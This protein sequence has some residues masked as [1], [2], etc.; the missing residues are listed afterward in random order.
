MGGSERACIR[1]ANALVPYYDVTVATIWGNAGLEEE[2]DNHIQ[3]IHKF[4]NYIRGVANISGRIPAK[5]IYRFFIREK[6]DIEVAVGDGLESY[7][8]SGSKNPNKYSWIHMNLGTYGTKTSD[9]AIKKYLQYKNIICVSQKNKECFIKE[10]GFEDKI[11]VC[12]TPVDTHKIQ[13][14]SEIDVHLP[15]DSIVAVGRLEEVKG[16]DRLIRAV[17]KL[18]EFK[19]KVFIYGDGTQKQALEKQISELELEDKIVLR[20]M[21][22]NPYPYIA[23][24]KAL[25]CSSREESFGFS[26]VEAMLLRTPVLA[27][28]CGGAEEIITRPE[29]GILCENSEVGIEEGLQRILEGKHSIDIEEAYNRASYFQVENCVRKFREIIEGKSDL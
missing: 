16:F 20:G 13:L 6:Y 15:E 7:I 11:K 27:T 26:I 25:V 19:G 24:A 2:L 17:K 4:P 1:M 3:V 12:Y 14:S 22:D 5:Y 9:K 21:V 10:M 23:K 8:I 28:R 18:K 29:E